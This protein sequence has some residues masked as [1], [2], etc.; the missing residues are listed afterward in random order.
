MSLLFVIGLIITSWPVRQGNL[1]IVQSY[2]DLAITLGFISIYQ[3][4]CV[5][6][7]FTRPAGRLDNHCF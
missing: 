2:Y 1:F 7:F 5:E 4:H 3:R 6:S